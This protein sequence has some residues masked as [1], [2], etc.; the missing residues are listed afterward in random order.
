MPQKKRDNINLILDIVLVLAL[1]AVVFSVRALVRVKAEERA[2]K[3]AA[4][5]AQYSV[6]EK[7]APA[8]SASPMPDTG[9]TGEEQSNNYINIV[10]GE[11]PEGDGLEVRFLDV[12]QG[13]AALI[14]CSGHAA[15]I[16]GG[17]TSKSSF[18]YS[19]LKKYGI[20][21]LDFVI[22][23]HPHVDHV[24]G[25][26][27]ALNFAKTDAAYCTVTEYDTKPFNNFVKY[28]NK[29]GVMLNTLT[30]GD[31]LTLG[32]ARLEILAPGEDPC[33]TENTSIVIKI[34]YG[35]V[36]FLFTGDCEELDE[37]L[38]IE[39]GC[40]LKC[41]VLKV[42][43]HGSA[44]S[45]SYHFLYETWP[46]VAVISAGEDNTYGHPAET[47]LS[48]LT[49]SGAEIYRTDENGTI[50]MKTDGESLFVKT[51]K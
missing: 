7:S 40:D 30:A 16:D 10:R 47:V 32:E 42:P 46:A 8:K 12:G 43:H 50:T 4:V 17:H 18:M 9:D 48:R 44:Y 23:S 20:D 49:D 37:K 26:A 3:E 29:Q 22:A 1:I 25:L 41:D 11:I 24:G 2:A 33:L 39:S 6:T 14:I 38:M 35:D 15:L 36:S 31:E 28:L 21:H 45:T 34:I 19:Y 5:T 27:G 51:E 13:D